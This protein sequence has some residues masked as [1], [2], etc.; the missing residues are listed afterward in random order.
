MERTK[1][2]SLDQIDYEGFTREIE[3]LRRDVFQS[4]CHQD[5]LHLIK[6]ERIGKLSTAAGYATAWIIPNPISALLI[7]QGVLT[8]WLLMHHI[9]HGGYDRVPGVPQRYTSQKFAQGWRR[10]IDWFDWILP[11]AWACEHNFLHH[12]HTG[13]D[14]DPDLVE[15]HSELLRNL[16]C[17]RAIKYLVLFLAGITWKLSYYAPNTL[18]AMESHKNRNPHDGHVN[19]IR[20]SN[21]FDVRNKLVRKLW[22]S[23][24]LPFFTFHF[25]LI[26][27]LFLPLGKAAVL[28][29]LIN[30]V[31]AE[32]IT[33][34][35]AFMIIGPN[36]TGVDLC[37]FDHHYKNKQEF[38]VN[39]VL[40]SVNY[41]T[42]NDWIDYPQM[43]L[44]YQIEHHLIP[45]LPMRKYQQIQSKVQALC[46]KHN[47]PYLQESVFR[48][49][50]KFLNICVGK[51]TMIR[52][53][54]ESLGQLTA[55][56]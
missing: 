36:H 54:S 34:F 42:G 22:L 50:R 2:I 6:M 24:Y 31:L 44:N 21:V 43:W 17:P 23:C 53:H 39:Q 12:Y 55:D 48:R 47:I 8:R 27:L 33:N 16:P 25:L 1:S 11:D 46:A 41:I 4:L 20:P 29:V 10:F 13:E 9:S 26:P 37:R 49:F 5:F 52:V 51:G 28:F 3:A 15:R 32:L 45:N 18:N 14:M 38:Y 7:G 56:H 40:G 30:R 35:H 19:H